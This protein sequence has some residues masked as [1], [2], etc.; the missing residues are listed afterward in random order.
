MEYLT[1]D[2]AAIRFRCKKSTIMKWIKENKVTFVKP[3]R[4]YLVTEEWI[5]AHLNTM[6]I[7]AKKNRA[8]GK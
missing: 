5:Q 6:T 4:T 3:G 7:P 1:T 8:G 2:E